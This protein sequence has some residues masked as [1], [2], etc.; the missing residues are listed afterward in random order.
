MPNHIYSRDEMLRIA[1]T[2]DLC[3]TA[4]KACGSSAILAPARV[5]K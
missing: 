4:L 2:I 5:I 3:A 1:R